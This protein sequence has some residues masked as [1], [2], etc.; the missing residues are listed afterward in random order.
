MTNQ[1]SCIDCNANIAPKSQRCRSCASRI[2]HLTKKKQNFCADCGVEIKRNSARCVPC[3]KKIVAGPI[4]KCRFCDAKLVNVR[5]KQ[6]FDCF[7]KYVASDPEFKKKKSIKSREVALRSWENNQIRKDLTSERTKL[8]WKEEKSRANLLSKIADS[9]LGQ[10]SRLQDQFEDELFT[11]G[12]IKNMTVGNYLIDYCNK[13]HKIA[14]EIN[15]DYWHC[16]PKDGWSEDDVHPHLK[17][18]AQEIWKKDLAR[19]N[20][21]KGMGYKVIVIWESDIKA[22]QFEI[23]KLMDSLNIRSN[24]VDKYKGISTEKIL[25]DLKK[26]RFKY[27]ICIENW[28]YNYNLGTCIRAANAFGAKEVF[29]VGKK[30]IDDRSSVGTKHWVDFKHL[31]SLKDL[32]SLKKDYSFVALDN[33]DGSQE[34]NKFDWPENSLII[35]GNEANGI[36]EEVLK[37]SDYV[38]S[39]PQFGSVRSLNVTSAAGIAMYSYLQQYNLKK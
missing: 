35:L 24:L 9:K 25:E 30:K 19:I 34:I 7:Q 22:G 11:Y 26:N 15:G 5:S 29:Y 28:Q 37:I 32:I 23:E 13:F 27:S 39:I 18:T 10:T 33:V 17:K 3:Y 8:L 4:V 2:K 38:V 14:I 21:L 36:S 20:D 1:N 6:C 31:K 12:F 16:N